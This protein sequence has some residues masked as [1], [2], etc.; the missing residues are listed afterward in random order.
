MLG[1]W[2]DK[3]TDASGLT[4]KDKDRL[5]DQVTAIRIADF[6]RTQ[7]LQADREGA[8]LALAAGAKPEGIRKFFQWD[9]QHESQIIAGLETRFE[10]KQLTNLTPAQRQAR[11]ESG[12]VKKMPTPG[13]RLQ[14]QLLDHPAAQQR[15]GTLVEIYGSHLL[16][17]LELNRPGSGSCDSMLTM[18]ICP[19]SSCSALPFFVGHGP[20][21]LQLEATLR[22]ADGMVRGSQEIGGARPVL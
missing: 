18:L 12:M 20:D 7:E 15:Y 4:P 9:A 19:H 1:G 8:Y 10:E 2:C 17:P 14:D 5:H 6:T 3:K 16:H 11:I 13:R 21:H 22:R